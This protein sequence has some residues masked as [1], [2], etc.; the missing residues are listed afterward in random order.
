MARAVHRHR[1]V[2]E[3]GGGRRRR[4]RRRLSVRV[5]MPLTYERGLALGRL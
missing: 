1:S 5:S 2:R 3:L 4:L